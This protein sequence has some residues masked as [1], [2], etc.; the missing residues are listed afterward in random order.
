MI[1]LSQLLACTHDALI[2]TDKDL[3]ITFWNDTAEALFGWPEKAALGRSLEE[4]IKIAVTGPGSETDP[5]WGEYRKHLVEQGSYNRNAAFHSKDGRLIHANVRAKA[6]R[7]ENNEFKGAA[8]S[9]LDTANNK[10]TDQSVQTC[11]DCYRAL[12]DMVYEGF[13]VL[14]IM[15]D[16]QGKPFDIRILGANPA[17]NK[18]TGKIVGDLMKDFLE[19]P[20]DYYIGIYNRLD[21]K[22][23]PAHFEYK[24]RSQ[25]RYFDVFVYVIDNTKKIILGVLFQD[26]TECRQ[27]EKLLGQYRE[28][29]AAAM[30]AAHMAYW[31]WDPVSDRTILSDTAS[32]LLGLRPGETLDCS[33]EGSKL[34]HPDDV[35]HYRSIVLKAVDT[36]GNWHCEYRIIKPRNGEIAWLEERASTKKDPETGMTYQSGIMW[37]I[38][39]RKKDE[40]ALLQAKEQCELDRKNLE[41]IMEVIPSGI[42]LIDANERKVCY[43]NRRAI[44]LYGCDFTDRVLKD[45]VK[46]LRLKKLDGTN[47]PVEELPVYQ[48]LVYGR[49]IRNREM[50]INRVDGT[51]IP[52]MAS[53]APLFDSEGKITTAIIIFDDI[54]EHKRTESAL[55]ESENKYHSLFSSMDEGLCIMEPVYDEFKKPIDFRLIDAN[56]AF[57]K[58][59]GMKNPVGCMIRSLFPEVEDHWLIAMDVVA[60]G[61]K[62]L[63]CVKEAKRLGRW[64]SLSA[65]SVQ[66]NGLDALAVLFYDVTRERVERDEMAKL[67]K[68]QDEVFA[69]VSHE[70]KTPLSVIFSTIQLLELYT[71]RGALD[72]NRYSVYKSIKTIKQNC[73]RFTKLINNIVDLSKI[74]SGFFK[75]NLS[76][77]NIVDIIKN[78]VQSIAEYIS[79]KGLSVVFDTEVEEKLIAC[80]PAK[81]ERVILNLI[82]NAIKFSNP[83]GTISVMISDHGD[84][85]EI[86][87][88]DTGIGIEEKYLDA[89]FERFNQVDKTLTRNAEGSG[90]GLSIVKSIVD[91]HN[92]S[93][94]VESK[95]GRGSTFRVYLPVRTVGQPKEQKQKIPSLN[96]VDM[97]NIEFSD[98]YYL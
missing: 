63:Q 29:L 11:V 14:E 74:D 31:D 1:E 10:K 68:V 23:G 79:G 97:I 59:T 51:T 4:I 27:N 9:F 71:Q 72:A 8:F 76:N 33:N 26:V 56:S 12:F 47:Y 24:S 37:D 62:P 49:E 15:S 65:F 21:L 94:S 7:D 3:V 44:E 5:K 35:E 75:L 45:H 20:L 96:R 88:R 53:S 18:L 16:E 48:S 98:I 84:Q 57:E 19:S 82:S 42:L 77:E 66:T 93:V 30:D 81:I 50:T 38:T 80:D 36:G 67:L 13:C 54:S 43:M 61:G 83:L 91:L 40:I 92:G 2:A 28:R 41:A 25:D 85:V 55:Q 52:I 69:N 64:F 90:I 32:G 78:I 22:N 95:V 87:V 89:I 60:H 73:Y 17:F 86:A 58:L 70:L 6:I 39:D 46:L 34:V